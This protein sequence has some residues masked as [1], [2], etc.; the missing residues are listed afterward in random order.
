MMSDTYMSQPD[1]V[2]DTEATE[3]ET[4]LNDLHDRHGASTDDRHAGL[5]IVSYLG[6]GEYAWL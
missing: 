4:G 1:C 6:I 3:S 2:T 5:A